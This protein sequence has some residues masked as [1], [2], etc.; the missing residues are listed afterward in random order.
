LLYDRAMPTTIAELKRS[1]DD[2]LFANGFEAA[3]RGYLQLIAA[4]PLNLD[5][6]LRVADTLLALGEVQRAAVVYTR[7]AQYATNAGYPLRAL[8]A[9]KIL[10][11][12]EPGLATLVRGVGE[13]YGRDSARLGRGAR[14]SLPSESDPLPEDSQPPSLP[15]SQLVV[16]AERMASNYAHKDVLFPEKLMPIVLLSQLD[17]QGLSEVFAACE[18]MRV[19]PGA[20]VVE[21]GSAGRAMFVLARGNVRVERDIGDGR[22]QQLAVLREGA[23]FGELSLLSG[24]PRSAA[25]RALV[26]CDLLVLSLDALQGADQARA[27][28]KRAVASFAHERLLAH[29]MASSTLFAVL[30]PAQ[31]VD[32]IKRFV[33]VEGPAGT[34]VVRQGHP[35]EGAYVVLRGQVRVRK[36]ADARGG[37]APREADLEV[38]L[39]R[40]G[41]GELFGEISL[42]S[43]AGATASVHSTEECALLFLAKTYFDRLLEALP[44]L[45]E[46]LEQLADRRSRASATM[47]AAVLPED[48]S[49]EVEV[50]L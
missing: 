19:R 46:E 15:L 34:E 29:V 3:L 43:G 40:L 22:T 24:A 49:F 38:E 17:T 48:E 4:Q 2:R 30:G 14:R 39:A 35:S 25:V 27:Q 10:G 7:L 11:A 12:L 28:L 21:Q 9:L 5:A 1:A 33:E 13:L 31:R 44:E 50:L 18:L 36:L 41:P 45:K 26:D 20:L 47:L 6:R 37:D 23:V 16:E 32:L 8:C 42:L